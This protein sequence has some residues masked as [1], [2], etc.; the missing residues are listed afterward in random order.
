MRQIGE[1]CGAKIALPIVLICDIREGKLIKIREYF[2]L[3]TAR[4]RNKA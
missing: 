2:D 4:A 1:V 3:Q